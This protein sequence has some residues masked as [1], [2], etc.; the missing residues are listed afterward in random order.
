MAR[1]AGCATDGTVP[2]RRRVPRPGLCRGD[3]GSDG[4]TNA[5]ADR[6][7]AQVLVDRITGGG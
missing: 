6:I 5:F 2:A 4:H 1:A 3:P 7:I